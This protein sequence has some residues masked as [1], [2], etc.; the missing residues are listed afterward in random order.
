MKSIS[1]FESFYIHKNPIDLRKNINGLCVIVQENMK[2][3]L[4]S[5]S[6]FV[7]CNKRRNLIKILYFDKS[8]FALWIKKL[9]ESKFPWP[10][11]MDEE[12]IFIEQKDLE[13]LLEGIN[14]WSKHKEVYFETIV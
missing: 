5:S 9:E 6:L 14:I 4:R 12:I 10:K 8:G 11:N 13:L 7:F 2:L 1:F 3:D